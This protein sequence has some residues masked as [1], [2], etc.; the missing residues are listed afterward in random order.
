MLW[1][2]NT[3]APVLVRSSTTD[4]SVTVSLYGDNGGRRVQA[5]TGPRQPVAGGDF[6]ITVTRVIRF[7]G[8]ETTRE[9]FT[10]TYE[11]PSPSG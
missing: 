11:T 10:T 6:R 2:N 9:S 3:E 7:P 1:T 8:G 5:L 4:T